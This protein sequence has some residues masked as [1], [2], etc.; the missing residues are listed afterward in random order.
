MSNKKIIYCMCDTWVLRSCTRSC[1]WRA[2]KAA[3]CMLLREQKRGLEDNR[4]RRNAAKFRGLTQIYWMVVKL[5]E[6][7]ANWH[8]RVLPSSSSS[9]RP[10]TMS[11]LE[12]APQTWKKLY[13][14]GYTCL[15][16]AAWRRLQDQKK[17]MESGPFL[18]E[19]AGNTGAKEASAT[20]A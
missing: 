6:Q 9:C 13:M 19:G 17:L 11:A 4:R 12:S 18:S 10:A 5:C 8:C 14:F 1:G 2:T 15:S 20:W 16:I 7:F 3:G